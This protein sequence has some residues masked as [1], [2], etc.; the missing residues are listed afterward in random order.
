MRTYNTLHTNEQ[1]R[2][3]YDLNFYEMQKQDPVVR[4][5]IRNFYDWRACSLNNLKKII[6]KVN[7][8][9]KIETRD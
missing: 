1:G 5:Y 4:D 7:K 3:I 2:R 9:Y 8:I 6:Q